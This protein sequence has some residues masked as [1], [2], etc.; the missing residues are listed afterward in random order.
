MAI[1][2]SFSATGF[3]HGFSTPVYRH[4][5]KAGAAVNSQPQTTPDNTQSDQEKWDAAMEQANKE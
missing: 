1:G 4:V 5:E 2:Y 3:G